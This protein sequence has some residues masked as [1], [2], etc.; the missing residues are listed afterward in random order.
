[1]E[2]TLFDD[3]CSSAADDCTREHRSYC[4]NLMLTTLIRVMTLMTPLLLLLP[5]P[6][7]L[8]RLLQLGH[9]RPIS[10]WLGD[11]G[12]QIQTGVLVL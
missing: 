7:Q 5:L 8:Q 10:L 12:Q 9:S 6:L 4:H 3:E 2:E 11:S 1:V